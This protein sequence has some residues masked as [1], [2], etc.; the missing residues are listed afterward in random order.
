MPEVPEVAGHEGQVVGEGGGGDDEVEV[1]DLLSD[2]TS[3][4]AADVGEAFEDLLGDGD[5]VF[6]CHECI[7]LGESLFG[8]SPVDGSL[9][10]FRVG[11]EADC[12]ARRSKRF[13]GRDRYVLPVEGIDDPVGVEQ[14]EA[15]QEPGAGSW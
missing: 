8:V 15:H 2:V 1:A 10:E 4:T 6:G 12:Q 11:D 3:E 14:E 5:D 7:D 13:E 9:I